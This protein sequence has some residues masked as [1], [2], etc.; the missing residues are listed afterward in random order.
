[1]ALESPSL[2]RTTCILRHYCV[3][4]QAVVSEDIPCCIQYYHNKPSSQRHDGS[5]ADYRHALRKRLPKQP[6]LLH[7]T[8]NKITRSRVT[9][10][11]TGL[12]HVVGFNSRLPYCILRDRHRTALGLRDDLSLVSSPIVPL[13]L[14]AIQELQS[15]TVLNLSSSSSVDHHSTLSSSVCSAANHAPQLQ[16]ISAVP[17]IDVST[18]ASSTEQLLCSELQTSSVSESD[19]KELNPQRPTPAQLS[20][21]LLKLREEASYYPHNYL[22]LNAT[23]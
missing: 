15:L 1:M 7:L 2:L 12:K 20:F 17:S 14:K 10:Q 5:S 9:K 3:A 23:L 11:Q 8:L 13:S 6:V 4:S 19:A 16:S 22:D 18:D 21:I